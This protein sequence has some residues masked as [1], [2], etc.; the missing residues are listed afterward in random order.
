MRRLYRIIFACAYKNVNN[1]S[2]FKQKERIISLA[3][4]GTQVDGFALET[5]NKTSKK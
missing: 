2:F 5:G 3:N 1:L 4:Y